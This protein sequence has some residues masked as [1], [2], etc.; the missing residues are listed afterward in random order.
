[1]IKDV[2]INQISINLHLRNMELNTVCQEK[3]IAM[4]M[5]ALKISLDI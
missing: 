2:T 5:H 3:G 4:T 1:M